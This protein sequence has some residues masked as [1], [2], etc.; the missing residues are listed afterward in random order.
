MST[1]GK[2]FASVS[3]SGVLSAIA[4]AVLPNLN[5]SALGPTWGAIAATLIGVI[6]GVATHHVT[7]NTTAK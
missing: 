6:L 3:I 7:V 1:F 5:T 2:V 4:V